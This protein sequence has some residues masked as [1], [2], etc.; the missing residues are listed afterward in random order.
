MTLLTP[1]EISK[2]EE[3]E[4]IRAEK[5]EEYNQ[6][7]HPKNRRTA[8]LL[9]IIPGLGQIYKG[10][11]IKGIIIFAFVLIGRPLVGPYVLAILYVWQ[12]LDAFGIQVINGKSN[13]Y[14]KI[15]LALICLVVIL[16]LISFVRGLMTDV[17]KSKQSESKPVITD[18]V[19][20][21][22]KSQTQ[23]NANSIIPSVNTANAD[24][25]TLES[26][27]KDIISKF[28]GGNTKVSYGELRIMGSDETDVPA[29]SKALLI[30][31]VI[32]GFSDKNYLIKNTANPLTFQLM[33]AAFTTK[34]VN[35]Y[36]VNVFYTVNIPSGNQKD[37]E[38]LNYSIIKDTYDKMDQ[39]KI[40]GNDLCNFLNEQDKEL[41]SDVNYLGGD[42]CIDK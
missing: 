2:I 41:S 1:E 9:S 22:A 5:R 18:S 26:N 13:V 8:L 21:P 12:M 30:D 11:I 29:G 19:L 35:V 38:V 7:A 17:D 20:T 31:V 6:T 10:E 37:T 33:H 40:G 27:F 39:A 23:D 34:M 28:K 32:D 42:G 24:Q 16:F 3:E 14:K 4:R 36:Y 15:G 25:Q